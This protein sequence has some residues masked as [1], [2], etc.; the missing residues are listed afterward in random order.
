VLSFKFKPLRWYVGV[1]EDVPED[2]VCFLEAAA[3]KGVSPTLS[4]LSVFNTLEPMRLGEGNLSVHREGL[5][6]E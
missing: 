4:P 3:E 1:Q 6:G 2:R 5:F